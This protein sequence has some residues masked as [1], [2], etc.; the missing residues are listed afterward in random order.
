MMKEI[1]NTV[2]LSRD[3]E[4][5]LFIQYHNTNNELLKSKIKSKIILS[6]SRF[7]L[8]VANEYAK[9]TGLDICDLYSEC[10][11]ALLYTFDKF[12]HTKGIKFISL[13]V[14]QMRSKLGNYI[15]KT[16]FI[17]IPTVKRNKLIKKMK[18]TESKELSTS[19]YHLWQIFTGY[20]PLDTPINEN[21]ETVTLMDVLED[22][23]EIQYDEESNIKNIM[24]ILDDNLTVEEKDVIVNVF[25]LNTT[26]CCFREYG[27]PI[28]KH[29]EW[30][31]QV[32]KRALKKLSLV[33]EL[34]ELKS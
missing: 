11:Y 19:D 1:N 9:N 22:K 23:R 10:K 13:A 34:H 21:E 29:S 32:R 17:H 16:D 12:D 26:Q 6:N 4:E 28:G 27:E 30:V 24:N 18:D 31:K 3:E 7:A 14:W 33:S 2:P 20:K 5:S 25:G 15:E 8:Q